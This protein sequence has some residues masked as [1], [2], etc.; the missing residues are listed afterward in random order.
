MA[1]IFFFKDSFYKDLENLVQFYSFIFERNISYFAVMK[2]NL[3]FLIFFNKP[4]LIEM[5]SENVFAIKHHFIY[6]IIKNYIFYIKNI[7]INNLFKCLK[8]KV[9]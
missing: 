6:N 2:I 9:L 8:E 1:F 5:Q 3:F 4:V 7:I